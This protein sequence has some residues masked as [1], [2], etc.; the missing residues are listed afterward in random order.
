MSGGASDTE[1]GGGAEALRVVRDELSVR[2]ADALV[3]RQG[4][5]E[6]RRRHK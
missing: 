1:A 5:Q 3:E 2:G 6:E 4:R